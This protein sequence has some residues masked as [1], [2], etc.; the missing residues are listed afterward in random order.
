MKNLIY[1]VIPVLMIFGVL[2]LIHSKNKNLNVKID[3]ECSLCSNISTANPEADNNPIKLTEENFDATVLNSELPF[4]VTFHAKWCGVCKKLSP[5]I[6]EL[7]NEQKGMLNFGKVDIDENPNLVSK[8]GVDAVP[9][10]VVF[11]KGMI[12]KDMTGFIDKAKLESVLT[13][14]CQKC[15][16]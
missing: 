8:Y 6:D 15:S 16:H 2:S 7:A 10:V 5:V 13:E 14:V 11:H 1:L 9:R 4:V 12:V 3:S